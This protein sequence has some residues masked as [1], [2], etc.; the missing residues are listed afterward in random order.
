MPNRDVRARRQA[1]PQVKLRH[2]LTAPVGGWTRRRGWRE[3]ECRRAGK[4]RSELTLRETFCFSDQNSKCEEPFVFGT[5]E[6]GDGLEGSGNEST[7][8]G[9]G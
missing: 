6:K 4:R 7:C 3:T 9:A 1:P 2:S 5:G 8:E